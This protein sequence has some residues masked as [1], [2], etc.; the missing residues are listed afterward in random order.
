MVNKIV[1]F[2]TLSWYEYCNTILMSS[3]LGIPLYG[4]YIKSAILTY[5]IMKIFVITSF[6][7]TAIDAFM[8]G[9]KEVP[10]QELAALTIKEAVKRSSLG[11]KDVQ[12][13]VLG[14]AI[15]TADAGNL[16]RL[17]TLMVV[18]DEKLTA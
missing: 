13:V 8:G 7:R 6:S 4:K 18:L 9:L 2:A 14:H 15:S 16:R 12:G 11:S 1:L 3:H 17:A 5:C 10:V